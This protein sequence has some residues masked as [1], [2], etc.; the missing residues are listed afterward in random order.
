MVAITIVSADPDLRRHLAQALRKDPTIAAVNIVGDPDHVPPDQDKLG[1]IILLDAS[2]PGRLA[3]SRILDDEKAVIVLLNG[4]DVA[5]S[6]EALQAGAQAVLS[7]SAKTEEIVAAVKAVM[8][9]LAVMPRE[10]A[11]TL[12]DGSVLAGESKDRL[13]DTNAQLT[14]RQLDVLTALA[15]GASN[16]A[17][18]RRLGIS[19]HTVKFHVA[20]ILTKLRADSRT[21]AVMRAAQLGLV[22]L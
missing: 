9:G 6:R 16:K 20:G 18:A 1:V 11:Q 2:S 22:M 8:G 3:G 4:N 12:V 5:A 13:A 14:P 19:I 7:R 17:I 10:L 21:E 15:D